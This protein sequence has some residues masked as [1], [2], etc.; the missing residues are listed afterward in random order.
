MGPGVG[1]RRFSSGKLMTEVSPGRAKKRSFGFRYRESDKT[2]DISELRDLVA[3]ET[4]ERKPTQTSGIKVRT[5]EKG[6]S[7]LQ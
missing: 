4:V 5:T 6:R 1:L 3:S 7:I 2:K